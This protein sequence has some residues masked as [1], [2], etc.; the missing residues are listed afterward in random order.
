MPVQYNVAFFL[1]LIGIE[2]QK[3]RQGEIGS[4]GMPGKDGDQGMPG[5]PGE[6]Y[7]L[8]TVYFI[9]YSILCPFVIRLISTKQFFEMPAYSFLLECNT[10]TGAKGDKGSQG[11]P[12]G[13]GT[14]GP[15]GSMGEMG[16][17]GRDNLLS[18]YNCKLYS[19]Y[20]AL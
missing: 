14:A 1:G 4:F 9:F 3:G 7:I 17:P 6:L 16:L 8:N 13:P 20:T 18:K 5:K 2:G 19:I 12:G 15:K 10:I 11:V